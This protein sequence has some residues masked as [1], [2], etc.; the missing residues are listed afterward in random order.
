MIDEFPNINQWRRA[1]LIETL[2][3]FMSIGGCMNFLQLARYR[4]YKQQIH[5][6]QFKKHTP[7]LSYFYPVL[8]IR[9]NGAW[10]SGGWPPLI[11]TIIWFYLL[12]FRLKEPKLI[13]Q[14]TGHSSIEIVNTFG[15]IF[16]VPAYLYSV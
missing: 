10:K 14:I 2:I 12:R 5:R 8:L 16:T 9:P 6:Q 3:L 13:T 7:G 11:L 15:L 4:K 1:F